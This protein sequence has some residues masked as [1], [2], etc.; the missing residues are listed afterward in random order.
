MFSKANRVLSCDDAIKTCNETT[1]NAPNNALGPSTSKSGWRIRKTE[2]AALS[3]LNFENKG[4]KI[5]EK[6]S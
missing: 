1:R 2:S 5:Q 3:N 4:G 6:T